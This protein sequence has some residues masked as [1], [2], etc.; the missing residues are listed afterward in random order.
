M[1]SVCLIDAGR[2]RPP[3]PYV[4]TR[5]DKVRRDQETRAA[6]LGRETDKE[7]ARATL[8]E[9]NLEQVPT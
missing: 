3:R 4:W 5:L 6:Q 2:A 1:W 9:Y 8:I 7:E